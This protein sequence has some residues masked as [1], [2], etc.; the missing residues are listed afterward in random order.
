MLS[1]AIAAELAGAL[2]EEPRAAIPVTG[3]DINDAY[4]LDLGSGAAFVK[5]RAGA[6]PA[7]FAA[8]AAG[9]RWL[10]DARAVPIPAVL[11]VG[12][13][14]A[15]LALEWIERGG[16]AD[17]ETLGRG[18]AELHRSGAPSHGALPPDSPDAVLRVG[19]VELS[20]ATAE[21]WPQLYAEGRLQPL[22]AR[23]RDLGTLTANDADAV[24]RVCERIDALAGPAEPP[25]R[26]HGDLWGGNVLAGTDGSYRLID[27]AAYGGHREID[28]A[29]LR[30]FGNP[31]E[32]LF[33]A[34]D[35]TYP[36]A[37]GHLERVALWQLFP[38]LIH[39]VLFGGAYGASA[40][41]AAR[42]YL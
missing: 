31:G 10:A 14:E 13:A 11:G 9:L 39:A 4:R 27:P 1:E 41:H 34:Y 32:R 18:L 12:E 22:V 23:A 25:A 36:L 24:D 29:M 5:Y 20:A 7:D 35:E 30:L 17:A 8:E 28:L 38:L 6:K 2:G 26:L 42:E 3:G 40:G 16:V 21:S 37:D 19:S 33:S 15:W